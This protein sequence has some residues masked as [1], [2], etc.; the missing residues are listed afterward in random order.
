M[1]VVD[2]AIPRTFVTT[3]T[4]INSSQWNKNFKILP[5]RSFSFWPFSTSDLSGMQVCIMFYHVLLWF[6][7]VLLWFYY[8]FIMFYYD[9]IMF[10]YDFI[11]IYYVFVL[12]CVIMILLC[13]IM[14]LLWFYY[15]LLWFY[16]DF[17]VF[18]YDFIMFYYVLLWYCCVLLWFYYVLLWFYYVFFMIL[19]RMCYYDFIM[20]YYVNNC[21]IMFCYVL[22]SAKPITR[23]HHTSPLHCWNSWQTKKCLVSRHF[24]FFETK[25]LKSSLVQWVGGF[26]E[27]ILFCFFI[28]SE[29]GSKICFISK[30]GKYS[31]M[32]RKFKI[33]VYVNLKKWVSK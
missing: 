4:P 32:L 20:F 30:H 3:T 18:Y 12:L 29:G 27:A 31:K 16:Y 33:L 11:I 22:L 28:T 5:R 2:F 25:T 17:I 14:I 19:L 6:Y 10:H 21:F 7:Y 1:E 9:F 26:Q 15:V 23:I 24:G 13:F 8:D